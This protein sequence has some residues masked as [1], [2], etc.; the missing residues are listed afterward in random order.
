[1]ILAPMPPGPG[2][3]L[4]VDAIIATDQIARENHIM[5]VTVLVLLAVDI[6]ISVILLCVK[7]YADS[8]VYSNQLKVENLMR[9]VD[10]QTDLVSD[11][12]KIAKGTEQLSQ[13]HKVE[14]RFAAEE[15]K[16]TAE[17][18]ASQ[19]KRAAHDLK[20]AAAAVATDLKAVA[21]QAAAEI[22]GVVDQNKS[23][24]S[25]RGGLS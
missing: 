22:K 23:D 1:M 12:L 17:E 7:W 19:A 10:A 14:T 25:L 9:K 21:V 6:I 20:E 15:I 11:L 18:A 4:V 3:D 5:L 8:R 13:A 24:P 16:H 2:R